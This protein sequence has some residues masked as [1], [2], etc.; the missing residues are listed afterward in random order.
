MDKNNDKSYSYLP[1]KTICRVM[2][3]DSEALTDALRFYDGYASYLLD[4]VLTHYHISKRIAPYEDMMQE[5]RIE[6]FKA[7][8][9]FK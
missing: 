6:L 8:R 3:G 4:Y 7:I 1:E 9:K 2:D 5:I